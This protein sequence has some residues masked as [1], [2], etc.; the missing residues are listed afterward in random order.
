MQDDLFQPWRERTQA[1]NTYVTRGAVRGLDG[2]LM[3]N[4]EYVSEEK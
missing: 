2:M 4:A 1:G 3:K